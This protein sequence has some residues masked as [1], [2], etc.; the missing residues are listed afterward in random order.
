MANVCNNFASSARLPFSAN[1]LPK[2]TAPNI[3][4]FLSRL[5]YPYQGCFLRCIV[6]DNVYRV[7]LYAAY[8]RCCHFTWLILFQRAL[9]EDDD[10]A[11]WIITIVFFFLQNAVRC[12][13]IEHFGE[14][15][16]YNGKTLKRYHTRYIGTCI[17]Q[18]G[19][20]EFAGKHI[21]C[22]YKLL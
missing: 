12:T 19:R 7:K 3:A 2:C 8:V 18:I 5:P 13:Q 14:F 15:T 21:K 6:N 17:L 20:I 11:L 16:I 1:K 22:T 9:P 4:V 10:D